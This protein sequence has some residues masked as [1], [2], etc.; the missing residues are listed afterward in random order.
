M[1]YYYYTR[2]YNNIIKHSYCDNYTN[3]IILIN[4]ALLTHACYNTC[5]IIVFTICIL[6]HLY[7]NV[8]LHVM[9]NGAYSSLFSSINGIKQGGI[10]SPFYL[11]CL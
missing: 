9:W 2:F 3:N 10:L 11:A 7:Y 5:N 6:F 8:D 1:L 4:K